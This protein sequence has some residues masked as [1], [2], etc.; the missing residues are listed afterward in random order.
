MFGSEVDFHHLSDPDSSIPPN[1]ELSDQAWAEVV[2]LENY[3]APDF[4]PSNGSPA[5]QSTGSVGESALQVFPVE[6][7]VHESTQSAPSPVENIRESTPL[8]PYQ[9]N[10]LPA[11]VRR[12]SEASYNRLADT[13]AALKRGYTVDPDG[14]SHSLNQDGTF[15]DEGSSWTK[16][17]KIL[18]D[19][20]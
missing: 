10:D 6:E 12:Y 7:I 4:Q 1:R 14:V 5:P 19:I 11:D 9:I 20:L 3:Y 16:T 2:G 13:A 18:R 8:L 15:V 17:E